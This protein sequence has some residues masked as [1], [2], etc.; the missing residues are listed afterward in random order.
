MIFA[1]NYGVVT[2]KVV[3]FLPEEYDPR[4]LAV[5]LGETR[6]EDVSVALRLEGNSGEVKGLSAEVSY[7]PSELEFVAARLTDDMLSPVGEVFF[8][9]GEED[10]CVHIDVAV[11]G[12]GV[13]IGGSGELAVLTFRSL[14][15][16]YQ[17]KVESAR[18]RGADNVE[19]D[20]RL[21]GYA[22]GGDVPAVFRLVQNSPNPFNPKTTVA[23]DVPRECDMTIR[24]YDVTGRCVRTLVDG[25]VEP[26]RHAVVW[27]GLGDGGE[28]VGS[29][30]YFCTMEAP[31][32][33][34]CRKMTLLK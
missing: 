22:A 5:A 26:G 32:F 30:I 11:L 2:A 18:L 10:G 24:V 33:R 3:P 27:D 14:A 4:P 20:A 31:G 12:T 9:Y 34:D 19:L 1:M 25:E 6:G 21:G 17:L 29:G 28:E 23:Y 13:T 16:T 7:D 8:W 15:G